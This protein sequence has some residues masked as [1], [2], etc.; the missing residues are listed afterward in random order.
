MEGLEK[1]KEGGGLVM[2]MHEEWET[3]RRG[4]V[5]KQRKWRDSGNVMIRGR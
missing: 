5:E 4:L 2:E 3:L 1:K